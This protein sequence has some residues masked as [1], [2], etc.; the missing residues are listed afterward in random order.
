MAHCR[1]ARSA[2]IL[3]SL[4][5]LFQGCFAI[6]EGQY[7]GNMNFNSNKSAECCDPQLR[8]ICIRK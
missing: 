8:S 5:V 4:L 1:V 6:A 3:T 2:C 7:K